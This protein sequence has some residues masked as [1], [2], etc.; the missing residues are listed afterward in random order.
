M[1]GLEDDSVRELFAA[2]SSLGDSGDDAGDDAGECMGEGSQLLP[3]FTR[4]FHRAME[5]AKQRRSAAVHVAVVGNR[6]AVNQQR[7]VA[8]TLIGTCGVELPPVEVL[9]AVIRLGVSGDIGGGWGRG[10]G[11]VGLREGAS[12]SGCGGRSAGNGVGVGVLHAGSTGGAG[13]R[14]PGRSDEDGGCDDRS[15]EDSWCS[16]NGG[17]DNGGGNG[18]RGSSSSEVDDYV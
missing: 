14:T 15:S 2:A 12:S 6:A 13:G 16:D 18:R 8:A 1:V 5:D 17:I 7:H 4:V 9:G 3:T 10:A 11:G